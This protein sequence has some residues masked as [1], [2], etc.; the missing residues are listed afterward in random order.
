MATEGKK[1]DLS[2]PECAKAG[3]VVT[4]ADPR[5]RA[6]HRHAAHGVKGTSAATLAYHAHKAALAAAKNTKK[7]TKESKPKV[8]APVAPV[9]KETAV[10]VYQPQRIAAIDPA[11]LGYAMG[12]LESLAV[13][14]AR[15]NGLPEK[16]FVSTVAAN[17]AQLTK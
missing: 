8:K 1:K 13:L 10:T 5:G 2:C 15:E 12:R 7:A 3:K 11:M 6:A 14:I 4:F 16:E 9:A 17:L